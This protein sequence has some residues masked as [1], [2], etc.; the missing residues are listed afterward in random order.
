[1]KR[2][3]ASFRRLVYLLIMMV[4]AI[5]VGK[6]VEY[7]LSQEGLEELREAQIEWVRSV[8]D[9]TPLALAT[10][11]RRDLRYLRGAD[12]GLEMSCDE[13][14]RLYERQCLGSTDEQPA[15]PIA[16]DC[17][18]TRRVLEDPRRPELCEARE[19]DLQL[20]SSWR[21]TDAGYLTPLAALYMGAQRLIQP[22]GIAYLFA[23]L[24]LGLGLL[25][26]MAAHR[27]WVDADR[28]LPDS[29]AGWLLLFPFGVVVA[30]SASAFVLKWFMLGALG[31]FGDLVDLAILAAGSTG[32]A[33]MAWAAF[34]EVSA[35]VA[36]DMLS[37]KP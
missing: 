8:S 29:A 19:A 14:T 31:I 27:I 18:A 13:Q 24:Q 15:S 6:A 30:A 11:Y 32:F 23:A 33:G 28:I 34:R 16:L 2:F 26:F 7:V 4:V 22:G 20:R 35:D 12:T 36:T 10:N 25:I 17:E 1:M 5:T 9:M 21:N 37:P 3:L